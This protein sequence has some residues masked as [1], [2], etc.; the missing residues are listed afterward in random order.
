MHEHFSTRVWVA[1]PEGIRQEL[2]RPWQ[3]RGLVLRLLHPLLWGL[4]LLVARIA[5]FRRLRDLKKMPQALQGFPKDAWRIISVGNVALGGTGKSPLI[6]LITREILARGERVAVLSRGYKS[7]RCACCGEAEIRAQITELSDESRE[8]VWDV[9]TKLGAPAL[10]GLAVI[11]DPVRQR[12]LELLRSWR[13]ESAHPFCDQ[14]HPSPTLWVLLDDG[15]QHR[16]CPRHVD[17]CLW[18]ANAMLRAPWLCLP[19]GVFRE[20]T[21]QTLCQLAESVDLNIWNVGAGEDSR[22]PVALRCTH[23]MRYDLVFT[24]AV[25]SSP[26]QHFTEM[27][28]IEALARGKKGNAPQKILLLSGIA[29]PA[30]FVQSLKRGEPGVFEQCSLEIACFPDHGSFSQAPP[31]VRDSSAEIVLTTGK[32]WARFSLEQEF[33]Q[34]SAGRKIVICLTDPVVE[35]LATAKKVELLDLLLKFQ[36]ESGRRR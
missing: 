29:Q 10:D 26:E 22:P 33:L 34:F 14:S 30:R 23:L 24:A 20:G 8:L 4:S 28:L 17:V 19:A 1:W 36:E 9:Q 7:G 13:A 15:M 25:L 5:Q 3:D 31:W 35:C 12:A 11:Q 6:R 27:P 16:Q 21:P 2:E 32:D 18:P